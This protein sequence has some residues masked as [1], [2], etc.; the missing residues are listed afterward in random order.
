M[1]GAGSGATK[2]EKKQ[3]RSALAAEEKL[4]AVVE[5]SPSTSETGAREAAEE[6]VSLLRTLKGECG[7]LD[8]GARRR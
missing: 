7:G 2:K 5:T 8:R 3:A 4:D 1:R 6:A